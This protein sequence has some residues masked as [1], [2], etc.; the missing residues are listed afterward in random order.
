LN[1]E[2]VELKAAASINSFGGN[3]E[4]LKLKALAFVSFG[5]DA[6]GVELTVASISKS[7][8]DNS[9]EFLHHSTALSVSQFF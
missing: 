1:A 5:G 8:L 3:A 9:G 6:E 2:G 4:G 7:S